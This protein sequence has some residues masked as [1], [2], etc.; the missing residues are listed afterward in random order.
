MHSNP[1]SPMLLVMMLKD[2]FFTANPRDCNSFSH[3]LLLR[4]IFKNYTFYFYDNYKHAS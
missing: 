3:Q 2:C 1:T 4:L